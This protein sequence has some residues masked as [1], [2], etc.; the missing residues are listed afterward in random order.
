VAIACRRRPSACCDCDGR[1]APWWRLWRSRWR[2]FGACSSPPWS[3]TAWRAR[4]EP[5]YSRTE[6]RSG[7]RGFSASKHDTR[8]HPRFAAPVSCTLCQHGGTP[9]ALQLVSCPCFSCRFRKY[10][11][12]LKTV[13]FLSEII[14]SISTEANDHWLSSEQSFI[15]VDGVF[16]PTSGRDV[17]TNIVNFK[18]GHRKLS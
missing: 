8:L 3:V 18:L 2:R 4:L 7:P 5:R 1:D 15:F 6:T 16:T 17:V 11:E 14:C 10:I 12:T 9:S 13:Y